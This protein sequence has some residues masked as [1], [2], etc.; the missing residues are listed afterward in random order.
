MAQLQLHRTRNFFCIFLCATT[1]AKHVQ[2]HGECAGGW[3]QAIEIEKL[4]WPQSWKVQQH[5]TLL[6]C[7]IAMDKRLQ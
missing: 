2:R 6:N 5:G 7:L 4:P 3:Q 1:K